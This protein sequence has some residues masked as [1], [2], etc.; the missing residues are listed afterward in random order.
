MPAP[1]LP[2]PPPASRSGR[3]LWLLLLLIPVAAAGGYLAWRQWQPA[4]LHEA[5]RQAPHAPEASTPHPQAS[6][7]PV[8]GT[9][10]A[11]PPPA[12]PDVE[13]MSGI[14]LAR[15]HVAPD[16]LV[17][18]AERRMQLGGAQR[19]D[20]LLL[21]Q[22]AADRGYAPADAAL[23]R[24]YDPNLP[25][26]ADIHPDEHEAALRYHQAVQGGDNSVADARAALKS[27]LEQRAQRGDVFAP[28]ILKDFW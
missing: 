11:P 3:H 27:Y 21:M 7:S 10:A 16:V 2:G 17:R 13:H 19:N 20:A 8:G 5:A 18:E 26:P 22:V 24:F 15:S 9:P 25:H 6:P 14:D 28:Q 12:T 23:G 4:A 1:P